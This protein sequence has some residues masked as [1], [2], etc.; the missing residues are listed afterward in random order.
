MCVRCYRLSQVN[1]YL[2]TQNVDGLEIEFRT[3]QKCLVLINACKLLFD[4]PD[5]HTDYKFEM[6]EGVNIRFCYR[7][8]GFTLHNIIAVF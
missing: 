8:H 1:V 6:G 4:E 3:E 5:T 7:L 2:H